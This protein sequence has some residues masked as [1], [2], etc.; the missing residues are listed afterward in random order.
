MQSKKEKGRMEENETGVG[1]LM[2]RGFQSPT[3]LL[4]GLPHSPP[5]LLLL[6]YVKKC[7]QVWGTDTSPCSMTEHGRSDRLTAGAEPAY[8]RWVQ[9]NPATYP[10]Q[11]Y[12]Y[13]YSVC[14][15]P[16]KNRG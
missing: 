4:C 16:I 5:S 10:G 7:V 2:V 8:E 13:T 3:W 1:D 9:L 15:N 14:M 6:I 12:T 11:V